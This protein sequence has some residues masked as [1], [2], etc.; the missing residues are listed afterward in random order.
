MPGPY[1]PGD[2]LVG[3]LATQIA[4]IIQNEI[5]SIDYVYTKVPDRAPTNNQVIVPMIKAKVVDDT[6]AKLK[7]RFTF[8]VRHLFRRTEFADG[9]TQAYSYIIPWLKMLSAWPNLT[10]G[11]LAIAT[12]IS[13]L[14]VTQI[15]ESGQPYVALAVNFDVLTEFNIDVA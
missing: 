15:V 10:L 1:V 2:T 3:P 8:G 12:Y 7:V 14:A 13:D 5:P 9:I 4:T 6:N 11:G